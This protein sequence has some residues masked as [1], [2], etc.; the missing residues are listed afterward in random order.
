MSYK[1]YPKGKPRQSLNRS[2]TAS[3]LKHHEWDGGKITVYAI[4]LDDPEDA[5]AWEKVFAA[6]KKHDGLA[7]F[8]LGPVKN[9]PARRWL[10]A[11]L[12]SNEWAEG[13]GDK[14]IIQDGDERITLQEGEF[15]NVVMSLPRS[16]ETCFAVGTKT[17]IEY[18][19]GKTVKVWTFRPPQKGR[20]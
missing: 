5:A 16:R 20:E 2:Q 14:S 15:K 13:L 9:G 19:D 12:T 11:V 17:V 7:D 18:A 1:P 3:V 4:D 6:W 8:V 10:K